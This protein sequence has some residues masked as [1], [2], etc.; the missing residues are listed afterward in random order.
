MSAASQVTINFAQVTDI[1]Q[2]K[3]GKIRDLLPAREVPR[4]AEGKMLTPKQIR[5]RARRK[6]ARSERMSDQEFEYL[7]KKPVEEWDLEE[8]AHGRPR[9]SNGK[10]SGP[11]PKW[12]NAAV[13]EEAMEKYT[14][15]IKSGMNVTTVDALTVIGELLKNE[16]LDDKGKPIVPPGTKLDAAKFLIEHVIGKPKQRIESDVSVKL[17]GILGAVM[18]NPAQALMAPDLGGEGYTMGHY[19]G[20]TMAMAERPEDDDAIDVDWEE[21]GDG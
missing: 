13:Y 2:H 21:G 10:F 6:M 9:N 20:I 18:V 5:A 4:T 11:K 7:Y 16:D 19:P 1:R 8:L 17:Q 15:A 3:S 14:M 12:I